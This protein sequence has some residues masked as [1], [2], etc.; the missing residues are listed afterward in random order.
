MNS[1]HLLKALTE[2]NETHSKHI[3][4]IVAR[5]KEINELTKQL[6]DNI[7]IF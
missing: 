5:Q 3:P 1:K 2:I 7:K 4:V 6:R